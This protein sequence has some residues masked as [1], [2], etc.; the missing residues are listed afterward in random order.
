MT[1]AR[2][3]KN[4]DDAGL[5]GCL[6]CATDQDTREAVISEILR[7]YESPLRAYCHRRFASDWAAGEEAMADTLSSVWQL[8]RHGERAPRHLRAWLYQVARLRCLDAGRRIGERKARLVLESEVGASRQ[9]Q[10]PRALRMQEAK[11]QSVVRVRQALALVD[12]I[13]RGMPVDRQLTH[14]LHM[15][16]RLTGPELAAQ[17]GRTTVQSNSLSQRHRADLGPAFEVNV[18]A[19]DPGSRMPCTQLNRPTRGELQSTTPCAELTDHLAGAVRI[20]PGL[21]AVLDDPDSTVALPYTLCKKLVHH[22]KI[23][24][25]CRTNIERIMLRWAPALA[26]LLGAGS[27]VGGGR[28]DMQPVA[29]VTPATPRAPGHSRGGRPIRSASWPASRSGGRPPSVGRH[30]IGS[31]LV[32]TALWGALTLGDPAPGAGD[33]LALLGPAVTASREEAP[34]TRDE[35]A[36]R[37]PAGPEA[38]GGRVERVPDEPSGRRPKDSR[39]QAPSAP[40]RQ[41]EPNSGAGAPQSEPAE[42][43]GAQHPSA[44]RPPADPPKSAPERS[45]P[46]GKSADVTTSAPAQPQEQPGKGTS[47]GKGEQQHTAR[48]EVQSSESLIRPGPGATTQQPPARTQP[49]P[50]PSG[51]HSDIA[52]R[53]PGVLTPRQGA[54]VQDPG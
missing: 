1:T 44:E 17:L 33:H 45:A 28:H 54:P 16:R 48:S 46:D 2:D 42:Q 4:Y 32:A 41:A 6:R 47:T 27:L 50:A 40:R 35:W 9:S 11:E 36:E 31:A 15:R 19:R 26:V 14:E 18:L 8:L 23:C 3:I 12:D 43:D 53:D 22:V 49:A 20:R 39:K 38:Q 29:S 7:R 37:G 24:A 5:V 13:V 52:Q 21:R 34:E 51:P 30:L 10:S 25:T